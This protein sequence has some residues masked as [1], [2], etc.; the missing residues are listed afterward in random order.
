MLNYDKNKDKDT[1]SNDNT[2]SDNHSDMVDQHNPY[3]QL[4]F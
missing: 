2:N 4:I 1:N 3:A